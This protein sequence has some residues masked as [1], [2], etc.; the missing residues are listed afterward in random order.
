MNGI[1][2]QHVSANIVSA[3]YA[4]PQC[5]EFISE[6]GITLPANDYNADRSYGPLQTNLC[7]DSFATPFTKPL[8]IIINCV[9]NSPTHA[10]NTLMMM[11]AGAPGLGS[12]AD[13]EAAMVRWRAVIDSIQ[14]PPPELTGLRWLSV[15]GIRFSFPGQRGHTNQVLVSSNLVN[16][17]VLASFVG[18]NGPII[19]RDTN[20]VSRPRAF[21]RLRRL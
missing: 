15:G 21:Y 18:T 8:F 14:A 3:Y 7:H 16:W 10:Q 5:D 4:Q 11:Q 2:V 17:T 6:Y 19:F 12:D 1:P 9:S 13:W 20:I